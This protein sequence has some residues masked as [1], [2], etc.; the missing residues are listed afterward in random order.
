MSEDDDDD[1]EGTYADGCYRCHVSFAAVL[2]SVVCSDATLLTRALF[3]LLFAT[4]EEE[5]EEDED[6]EE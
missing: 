5:E 3:P 2:T 1:E 6:S 4:I